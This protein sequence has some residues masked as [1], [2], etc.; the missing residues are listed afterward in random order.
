MRALSSAAA[1]ILG[2]DRRRT[3]L[4]YHRRRRH[5][6][7]PILQYLYDISYYYFNFPRAAIYGRPAFSQRGTIAVYVRCTLTHFQGAA[8]AAVQYYMY[9]RCGSLT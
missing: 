9:I 4:Q 8:A 1:D 3:L 7:R 5:H 2:R 6:Y